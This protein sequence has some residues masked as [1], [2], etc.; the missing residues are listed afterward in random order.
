MKRATH[1]CAWQDWLEIFHP[2]GIDE[3]L[4]H[5]HPADLKHIGCF[6]SNPKVTK[7]LFLAGL[8]VWL[9]HYDHAL[10]PTTKIKYVAPYMPPSPH[11]ITEDWHDKSGTLCPF[12]TLHHGHTGAG[13]HKASWKLGGSFAD[14]PNLADPLISMTS[15]VGKAPL[16]HQHLLNLF[17]VSLKF[18]I[19][20]DVDSVFQDPDPSQTHKKRNK[21]TGGTYN[22]SSNTP[23]SSDCNR[24]NSGANHNKWEDVACDLVPPDIPVWTRALRQVDRNLK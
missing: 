13:H 7:R 20:S 16:L 4:D 23:A 1:C 14:T 21:K 2:R 17:L 12:P 11:I 9:I 8:P 19:C 3:S 18:F 10:P 15:A 6:A 5:P 24:D 22:N